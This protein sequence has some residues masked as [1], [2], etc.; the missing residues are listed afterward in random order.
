MT[1]NYSFS[2][3]S[4]WLMGKPSVY[5]YVDFIYLWSG[6]SSKD[7][8]Q[9]MCMSLKVKWFQQANQNF[10]LIERVPRLI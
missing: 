2:Y 4:R 7:I 6:Q 5:S 3:C 10:F 9:L 1:E 8:L